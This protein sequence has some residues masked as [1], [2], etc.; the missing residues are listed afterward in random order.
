MP[1]S[2]ILGMTMSG[3]TTLAKKLAAD[4][5]AKGIENII[6]DPLRDPQWPSNYIFTN[7]DQFTALAEESTHCALFIDESGESIGRNGGELNK[8]ATRYRHFGHR[9]HFIAQRAQQLDK[10][11]RDQ[12]EFLWCFRVSRSDAKLL[13][14]EYGHDE[15]ANAYLLNKGECYFAQRYKPLQKFNVFTQK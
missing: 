6:L 3:K 2:L 10:I 1:H 12:C 13:A 15:L 11:V 8:I 4:Y 7:S 9:A 14:E 5:R